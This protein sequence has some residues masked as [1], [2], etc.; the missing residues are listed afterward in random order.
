LADFEQLERTKIIRYES[1]AEKPEECIREVCEFIGID[2][3][4]IPLEG[5]WKV[6]KE[7]STISNKNYRS[8]ER[9]SEEDF[10]IIE[11]EAGDALKQLGYSRPE[12]P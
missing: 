11:E 9:L 8:F 1:L 12:R 7:S 6:H 10:K 3:N 5:E 4:E 2:P